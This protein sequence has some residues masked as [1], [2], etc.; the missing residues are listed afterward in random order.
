[1]N[2]K[3]F[4][5]RKWKEET[6]EGN[7]KN[8]DTWVEWKGKMDRTIEI[9][10]SMVERVGCE[11]TK[12]KERDR[13]FE[14]Q[15]ESI[16]LG[17]CFVFCIF[18]SNKKREIWDFIINQNSLVYIGTPFTLAVQFSPSFSFFYFLLFFI[19]LYM[20]FFIYL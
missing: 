10:G 4:L 6:K 5:K 17:F 11:E 9:G 3:I 7:E 18:F 16:E 8:R 13:Y 1:M 19:G 12:G 2:S 20:F 15:T 14:A